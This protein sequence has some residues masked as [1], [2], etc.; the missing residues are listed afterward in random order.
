MPL[1]V[2]TPAS[3]RDN[4]LYNDPF[5]AIAPPSE[6]TK[7]ENR[8]SAPVGISDAVKTFDVRFASDPEDPT[9]PASD[10][11]NVLSTTTTP[12][13][14]TEPVT[15]L[16]SRLITVP[17]LATEPDRDRL[18]DRLIA[19]LLPKA[20]ARAIMIVCAVKATP[21]AESVLASDFSTFRT[22]D[23][24]L[25]KLADRFFLAV[26]TSEPLAVMVPASEKRA[27]FA[28]EPTGESVPASERLVDFKTDP[29]GVAVP[30]TRLIGSLVSAPIVPTAPLATLPD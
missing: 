28:S 8:S 24:P 16:A 29:V 7:A 18:I 6:R 1:A 30:A 5:G 17:L 14:V 13:D 23:P 20:P 15:D 4:C 2:T 19:P 21:L 27:L 12:E 11:R 9:D 25:V 10:R 22:T 3:E 26:F